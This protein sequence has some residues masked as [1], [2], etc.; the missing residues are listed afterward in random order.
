MSCGRSH[1]EHGAERVREYE[2]SSQERS[3]DANVKRTYDEYQDVALSA[4]R[5]S[6]EHYDQLFEQQQTRLAELN[7]LSTQALQNS[8]ET[9]NMVAKQAVRHSD[10]AIDRQW[11]VDEV[12]HLVARGLVSMDALVAAVAKAIQQHEGSAHSRT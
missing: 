6:Q 8:V 3:W 5:R 7:Q 1:E 11:N 12:A 9:A 2:G 4:A 10:M